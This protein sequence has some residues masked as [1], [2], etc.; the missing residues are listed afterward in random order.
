MTGTAKDRKDKKDKWLAYRRPGDETAT[1]LFF[2]PYAGKGASGYREL[3]D[4]FGPEVEPVLVQ[5]PGREGRLA[6]PAV[7]DIDEL[8]GQLATA[9]RDH[10]DVPFAFFG[11]SMGSL[12]AFELAA[13]LE[14][15]EPELPGPVGLFVSAE[16]APHLLVP[17]EVTDEQLTDEQFLAD[18]TR[19]RDNSPLKSDPLFLELML[20]SYRADCRLVE[21][22]AARDTYSSVRCPISAFTGEYDEVVPPESVAAWKQ[23]TEDRFRL[24]ML[25]SGEEAFFEPESFPLITAAVESDLRAARQ[26]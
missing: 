20:P 19:V 18:P 24:R 6:E 8:V 15:T 1:R 23:H 14:R 11:H 2:L 12:I 7:P 21:R 9:L 22:Y 26:S 3:A 17:P 5:T 4:S 10:L 25:P 13:R 16:S